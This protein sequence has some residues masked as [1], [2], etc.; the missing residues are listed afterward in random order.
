[1]VSL[2]GSP[3]GVNEGVKMSAHNRPRSGVEGAFDIRTGSAKGPT[4]QLGGCAVG[5]LG[6]VT[7]EDGAV[8]DAGAEDAGCGYAGLRNELQP[9]NQHYGFPS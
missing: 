3:L 2:Q 5:D 7:A 6:D 4:L 1:M 8:L 9:H